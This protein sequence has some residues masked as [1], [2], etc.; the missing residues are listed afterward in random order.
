VRLHVPVR[1]SLSC[2]TVFFSSRARSAGLRC[3]LLRDPRALSASRSTRRLRVVLFDLSESVPSVE[4]VPLSESESVPSVEHVPLSESESVPSVEHVPLS[5]SESV[6]SVEHVPLSESES[7]PSV[8]HVPLSES[9]SVPSVEHAR[10]SESESVPSVTHVPRRVPSRRQGPRDCT[11]PPDARTHGS[12]WTAA[13]G[14]S[15]RRARCAHAEMHTA[16]GCG[17]R[18]GCK[19]RRPA[20]GSATALGCGRRA[21]HR[22]RPPLRCQGP[23]ADAAPAPSPADAAP[24]PSPADAAPAPR[25]PRLPQTLRRPSPLQLFMLTLLERAGAN[26]KSALWPPPPRSFPC[27]TRLFRHTSCRTRR[28]PCRTRRAARVSKPALPPLS[29]PK[30]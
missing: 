25:R 28:L 7:V 10:L 5:E 29:P 2:V 18:P 6:P 22:H 30:T 16:L 13:V 15:S 19:G 24:A 14:R 12:T 26:M 21:L 20:L 17:R 11:E 23:P 8:E 1:V 9:E 3:A 27:R 4:H